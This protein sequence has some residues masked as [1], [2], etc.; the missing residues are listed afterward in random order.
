MVTHL[1]LAPE[2]ELIVTDLQS[3]L[4]VLRLLEAD[5]GVPVGVLAHHLHPG[6]LA[7]LLVLVEQ[8]VL[9]R[10]VAGSDRQVAH[11]DTERSSVVCRGLDLR[12]GFLVV[13]PVTA[14]TWR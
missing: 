9:Q 11:A 14:R 10:G 8:A 3:L 2:E 12:G 5:D 4:G 1:D 13:A 7:V 6:D